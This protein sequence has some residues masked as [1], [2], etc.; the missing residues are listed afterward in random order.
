MRPRIRVS[1]GID[2]CKAHALVEAKRL[3]RTLVIER[4]RDTCQR[5]GHQGGCDWAHLLSRGA[6]PFLILEPANAI[7]LCR[8]C[9]TAA[10]YAPALFEAWV[11]E[12][13]PGRLD[14]LRARRTAR[15]RFGTRLELGK[16]IR[17]LGPDLTPADRERYYSGAWLG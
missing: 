5:C 16:V 13:W 14:E 7:A 11:V 12:R 4:D 8:R 2:Y 15:E 17:E 6:A 9:H 3:V 10:H 1:D